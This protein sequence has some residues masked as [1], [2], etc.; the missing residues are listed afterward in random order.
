MDITIHEVLNNGNIKE[1]EKASGGAWGGTYV[2]EE[3]HKMLEEIIG[4]D[5]LKEYKTE[6]LDDFIQICNDLEIKKRQISTESTNINFKIPSS[7]KEKCKSAKNC[8]LEDL[9]MSSRFSKDLECKR[10]KLHFKDSLVGKLFRNVCTEIVTHV[11]KLLQ[12]KQLQKVETI[13]MVGGFSESLYLQETIK[14]EFRNFRIVIPNEAGLA[15]LKGAVLFGHEPQIITSRIAKYTYGVDTLSRF[16]PGHHPA[17]RKITVEDTDYCSGV[18]SKHVTKGDE[19]KINEAQDE[20]SYCPV[21][22]TQKAILFN[23]YT[24]TNKCPRY[25]DDPDCSYLGSLNVDIPD[26]T[27]GTDRK[28]FVRFIFGGTEIKVEGKN[29]L[30]GEITAVKFDY[31]D[32]NPGGGE[33]EL[34]GLTSDL[35]EIYRR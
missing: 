1:L 23:V 8:K 18:F 2:D 31:F 21:R 12:E 28:V 11:K 10:D 13:L 26:T 15:V 25:V 20:Q 33:E 16:K 19:L 34:C 24:S 4:K 27:G 32:N 29:D 3:F 22:K 14:S 7:L 35:E 9:I 5:E 30:T 17:D 6:H